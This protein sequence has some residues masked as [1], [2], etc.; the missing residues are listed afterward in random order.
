MI[1]VYFVHCQ[2]YYGLWIQEINDLL[3]PIYVNG[4]FFVSGYLIMRKQLSKPV[5]D[6]GFGKY[7]C[8]G[9]RT[10]LQTILFKL[11]IPTIVF[12]LIEYFPKKLLRG[13]SITLS[14]FLFE[15]IGGGTYWFT[16]A[17]VVAEI[18][19]LIVLLTRRKSIWF[20]LIVG[21]VMAFIGNLLNQMDFHLFGMNGNPW[22][23]LNGL[24]AVAFL[25]AGGLYWKYEVFIESCLKW[26]LLIPLIGLY[27]YIF[28]A[29]P[30]KCTVLVSMMDVN[31]YGYLASL[32]G[33]VILVEV[34][35]KMK[36][37]SILSFIGKNSIC[38]YF[39]SGALPMIV[40]KIAHTF[41]PDASFIILILIMAV[42]LCGA[43]I[44]TVC[45]NRYMPFMLDLRKLIKK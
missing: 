43:G 4:F 15:T 13:E 17:L 7:F 3:H 38:F 10:F 2:I 39:L 22:S 8:S 1:A 42:C 18:L 27:I 14:S 12:S 16:S 36:Q 37:V 44:F 35:K 11:I 6:E 25:M 45:L 19:I 31:I 5:A 24:L 33:C 26:Y 23:Y 30:D 29:I 21:F 28:T 41:L 32:L 40:S 20:Y 9:G 34:C